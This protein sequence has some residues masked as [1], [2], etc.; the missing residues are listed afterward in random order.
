MTTMQSRGPADGL[1]AMAAGAFDEVRCLGGPFSDIDD[2]LDACFDEMMARGCGVDAVYYIESSGGK[3][4][5]R[6]FPAGAFPTD[7][8]SI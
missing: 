8:E 4:V 1:Y 7:D 2:V 6:A 3:R 5:A